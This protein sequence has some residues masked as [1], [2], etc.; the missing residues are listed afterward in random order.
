M[1]I[2][3]AAVGALS[4]V[5]FL[6]ANATATAIWPQKSHEDEAK[7]LSKLER[8]KNPVKK[9]K[10]ETKLGRLKL[11]NAFEAYD[12]GQYDQCWKLLDEYLARMNNAW[13]ELAASGRQAAKKPDGFKQ[14]EIAL[15]ESR[16][17]L[18]DFETRLTYA[19]RQAAEKIAAQTVQLHSR[20]L[21]AL[22]PG[23]AP[24][25]KKGS[26]AS[27]QPP[28]SEPKKGRQ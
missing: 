4:L 28:G 5:L 7:L 16:R 10:L 14:L 1:N 15:R 13:A 8:E 19:E 27:D 17:D 12:K 22:F 26:T 18:H 11:E 25:G 23:A 6:S 2:R 24:K 20:V 9:A 21:S 3:A